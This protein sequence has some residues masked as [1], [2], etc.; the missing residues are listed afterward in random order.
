MICKGYFEAD[1]YIIDTK[2]TKWKIKSR[3][4]NAYTK[5]KKKRDT[6]HCI[7]GK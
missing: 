4:D 2:N 5:K 6:K 3:D 1:N 7:T